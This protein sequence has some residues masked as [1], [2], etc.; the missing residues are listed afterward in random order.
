M[1]DDDRE[2][3]RVC[4]CGSVHIPGEW[5]E[6]PVVFMEPDEA[7][8]ISYMKRLYEM[9]AAGDRGATVTMGPFTAISLIGMFQ[10]VTRH[11]ELS[12]KHKEMARSII[13]QLEP[14]FVGTPGEEIVRRG[15]HPEFDK[16]ISN[17]EGG[18][19]A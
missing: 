18:N 16:H 3:D 6:H 19:A 14:L 12:G 11:P 9:E 2:N 15:N 1:T 7:E 10:L 4:M 13:R 17:D 8:M 5:V